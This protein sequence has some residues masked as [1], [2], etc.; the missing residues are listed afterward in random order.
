MNLIGEIAGEICK[1]L[2]PVD[3]RIYFGNPDSELAVCTLSSM[4][5]LEQIANSDLMS[6]VNTAGRLMSENRGVETLVRGVLA[7][8]RIRVLLL[9][10]KDAAGHRAG[11]SLACLHGN[12]VDWRGRIIG[13][14]SPDPLVRLSRQEVTLF[15]DTV[16]IIDRIGE[17]DI[18]K[19]RLC[20][21]NAVQ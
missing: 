1:I 12:G 17:D 6:E 14:P 13:S 10:G 3:D 8:G 4:G 5:L 11:Q 19:I 16:R 9:C 15:Q 21:E 2:L 18:S 20:I 7:K